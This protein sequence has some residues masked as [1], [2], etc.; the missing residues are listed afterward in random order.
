MNIFKE[1]KKAKENKNI[2][3]LDKLRDKTKHLL[4]DKYKLLQKKGILQ[5]HFVFPDNKVFLRMHKPSRYGDDLSSVRTDF[6]YTNTTLKTIR[7]FSQGRTTHAFRN[8]YPIIN[9]KNE[10][11]GAIEISFSSELLQNYFTNI[12][13][14]HTH[15]LVKKN[16]FKSH[17]WKRDDLVLKYQQSAEHKNYMIT[18]TDSHSKEKCIKDNAI[19][20][21]S[22]LDKINNLVNNGKKFSIY[23]VLN[24]KN[25][26]LSF[27]PIKH[28]FTKE[29][30]A[31]IVSYD[32]DPLIDKSIQT[33]T[34]LK[35]S[36][37]IALILLFS[38]IYYIIN[39]KNVL[40][41]LVEEKTSSLQK[42]NREL[43]ESEHELEIL[44]EKLKY[45]VQDEVD[46]N[47]EKDKLLFEQTKMAALG[48]MIANIAHQWRQPLSVISTGVTGMLL[49]K[50]FG[51]LCDE[52]FKKNC[53]TINENAQYLSKTIDDFKNFIQGNNKKEHFNLNEAID[54]FLNLVSSSV[55]RHSIEVI[56]N[57]DKNIHVTTWENELS[58]CLINLLNNSKDAFK[59]KKIKRIITIEGYLENN[60]LI[61]KFKDNAGGISEDIIEKI[62]EPYF[63]TK[64]KSQGTGLGLNMTYRL[65]T[66]GM[67][68]NISVYN[69]TFEYNGETYTGAEFIIS[70]PL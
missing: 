24:N 22:K 45:K 30:V 57:I 68:G 49:Q 64:H 13:K 15:F 31:W 27:Y 53:H 26:I 16:I 33:T 46:K 41:D 35:I 25:I 65:I 55:K 11:L 36:A 6:N 42:M 19:R 39:Q 28:N 29:I 61:I 37:F 48:E 3:Q 44:N 70:I 34:I 17:A 62:F 51:V 58:Q 7:G 21:S 9:N 18:M 59:G 12:N 5:Y 20:L 60:E 32:T 8:V 67:K 52:D 43:E 1:A 14:L 10:H 2:K 66:E 38:F 4:E 54:S 40:R 69:S 56:K 50:E 23:T 47:R 63:T